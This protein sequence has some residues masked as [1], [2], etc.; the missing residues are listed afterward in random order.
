MTQSENNRKKNGE[1][2]KAEVACAETCLETVNDSHNSEC[3]CQVE[4]VE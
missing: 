2:L 4:R 1:A 3:R